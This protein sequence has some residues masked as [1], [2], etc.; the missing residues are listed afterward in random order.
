MTTVRMLEPWEK[1]ASDFSKSETLST[2]LEQ[3]QG[4]KDKRLNVNSF[5]IDSVIKAAQILSSPSH[6]VRADNPFVGE[7]VVHNVTVDV[8]S[9]SATFKHRKQG[10]TLTIENIFPLLEPENGGSAG[11]FGEHGVGAIGFWCSIWLWMRRFLLCV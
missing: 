10:R 1:V 8:D 3:F 5:E 6:S 7:A 9:V 2:I 4:G 11:N